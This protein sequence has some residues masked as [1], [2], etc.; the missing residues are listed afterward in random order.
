MAA[1]LI[2]AQILALSADAIGAAAATRNKS[3]AIAIAIGWTEPDGRC[4]FEYQEVADALCCDPKTISRAVAAL[5]E[6]GVMSP[7][8][9]IR[10]RFLITAPDSRSGGPEPV[11]TGL[12]VL[13]RT[14]VPVDRNPSPD[15]T[16]VPVDSNAL[17]PDSRSGGQALES[18]GPERLSVVGGRGESSSLESELEEREDSN[19]RAGDPPVAASPA[20]AERLA[21]VAH[22]GLPLDLGD[23]DLRQQW[24]N[25]LRWLSPGERDEVLRAML[26]SY[27]QHFR[28]ATTACD[29]DKIRTARAAAAAARGAQARADADRT[30][31]TAERA[32][33]QVEADAENVSK[34][35]ATAAA[36]AENQ[37]EAERLLALATPAWREGAAARL[38]LWLHYLHAA[39]QGKT[40]SALHL[41]EVRVMADEHEAARAKRAAEP[42][43]QPPPNPGHPAA[44]DRDHPMVVLDDDAPPLAEDPVCAAI[45]EHLERIDAPVGTDAIDAWLEHLVEAGAAMTSG[46]ADAYL[47][48]ATRIASQR[49]IVVASPQD[50]PS[51]AMIAWAGMAETVAP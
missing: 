40:V 37:P 42:A 39:A 30:R 26:G 1:P 36:H 8:A 25:L 9:A 28:A 47:A 4:S 22:H 10:C 51:A 49:G 33:A 5:I 38:V 43:P 23:A 27:P 19:A 32:A 34:Q 29:L 46:D 2:A 11:S 41:R 31:R 3:V 50:V 12:P 17:R 44:L 35:A 16:A 18:G 15:R 14:A 6:V 21:W 20:D 24:L 48:L 13:H 7:R 45:R